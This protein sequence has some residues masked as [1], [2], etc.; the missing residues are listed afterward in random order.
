MNRGLGEH[1][2]V[3]VDTGELQTVHEGGV[4]HAVGLAAGADAG[5]PQLAEVSLLLLA[6]DVSVTAGLHDLLVGHLE[7][8]GL[9]APVALG[10]TEDLISVLA[11]HHRAFDSCH[12]W[13]SS[14]SYREQTSLGLFVG[15]H[16][17]DGGVVGLVSVGGAAQTTA[18]LGVLLGEDMALVGVGALDLAGLGE[19]ESL[20]RTAVRFQLGHIGVLLPRCYLLLIVALRLRREEHGHVSPLELGLLIQIG[21][22]SALLGKLAEQLLANVGMGHLS[23]AEADRDLD[24]VAVA[25]ELLGIFQLGVEIV[26]ADA[27][28]HPNLLHLNDVLILARFL[29]ALGL[30]EAILAVVHDLAHGRVGARGDLHE[31]EI[32]LLSDLQRFL[33]R[34]DAELRTV[35]ADDADLL[36]ADVVIDLVVYGCDRNTPPEMVPK[37]KKR[38]RNATAQHTPREKHSRAAY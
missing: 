38:G 20:L 25:E 14:Y 33:G 15:N 12:V 30:L 7:V 18:A 5:D 11:R 26:L 36:I 23:A 4:V 2:A 16:F 19:I 3:H 13:L 35:L 28:R 6:A 21:K 34:H 8:L 32:L 22:L 31:I 37:N 10:E 29:L 9:G 27:G 1:L 17:L 24:A